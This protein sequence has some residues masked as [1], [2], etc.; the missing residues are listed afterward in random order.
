M[1]LSPE[2]IRLMQDVK[3]AV[4]PKGILNPGKIFGSG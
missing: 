4:D 2:A 1:A 3:R